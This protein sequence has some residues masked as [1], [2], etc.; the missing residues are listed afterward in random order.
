MGISVLVGGC[1]GVYTT[2]KPVTA[3]IISIPWLHGC[4]PA[5]P[6]VT[7]PYLY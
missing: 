3:D 2:M 6:S 1:E 7:L 5:T 4:S